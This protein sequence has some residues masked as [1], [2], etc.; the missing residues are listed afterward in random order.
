MRN[1][2]EVRLVSTS[3]FGTD[4]IR[5]QT[6]LDEV[7]EEEAI[8][9]ILNERTLTPAFMRILGEALSHAS[10][11][12]P[13]SS[14]R[15]VVGWDARPHN[16]AL[17][18]ALTLGLR[19]TGSEVIHIGQCATPSLHAA[20]LAFDAQMGC[21]ITASHNPVSDSGIKVF[22]AGG[23]KSTR[24]F[25]QEV[26]RTLLAL[27]QEDREVDH[28]DREM[29]ASPD[30]EHNGW[31]LQAHQD[32]LAQR[33]TLFEHHFGGFEESL[34]QGRF[35]QPFILDC[36]GGFAA[37]W[38]AH[39]LTARGIACTEV[40]G[41]APAL[42]DGCG[43]GDFSPTGTWTREEAANAHHALLNAL[44]EGRPG[45][46]VGAALDGDGDRCL[47][48]EATE[49]GYRVVDGDGFAARL[50]EAG[51]HSGPWTF[52]AS[53]ESDVALSG[54]VQSMHAENSVIETAVG[55]RWLS[56]ALREREGGRFDSQAMP[57]VLGI[58]DSGH[59]VMPAPHISGK[60]GWSLVGD[61]AAT[62]CA[63]LLAADRTS[64]HHFERGWKQRVSIQDSHRERW[65]RDAVL[66]KNL[67]TSL[68]ERLASLGFEAT[69]RRI[70]GEDNLLLIHG[71]SGEGVVSFGVRNSGTQAKTS[72]SL[73]LSPGIEPAPFARLLD[74]TTA[75]LAS[76]L[77]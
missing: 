63:V 46:W 75:V 70:D 73:R 4:G 10:G 28:V 11:A 66:F 74:E 37:S 36:A 50:M 76:A 20:V 3:F 7:D 49:T 54:Y 2:A 29:L 23:Y 15:V 72:L 62:L 48:I 60:G 17:V 6:S 1:I 52:A 68:C 24:A 26:S 39:F 22:D 25:E 69:E 42:N 61:G 32:W 67:S 18:A 53:I 65:H 45:Q 30:E 19:L 31:A 51:R 41:S 59:V 47:L 77:Q 44:P 57:T 71:S 9:R 64:S 34:I 27:S 56:F 33:W 8:H 12:Q 16:E 14:A 43:A 38:L 58:E 13:G 55:D 5:G 35:A 21:M 40:S